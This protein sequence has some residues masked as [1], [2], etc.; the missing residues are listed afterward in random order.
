MR[1]ERE[2]EL[3]SSEGGVS[4]LG[5]I[6]TSINADKGAFSHIIQTPD[7][8]AFVLGLEKLKTDLQAVLHQPVGA[9]LS[10]TFAPFITLI[11]P[12]IG[13]KKHINIPKTLRK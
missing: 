6:L 8:P 1:K 3:V 7:P 10:A 9:H 11:D 2:G 12:T 4:A 5:L 13:E